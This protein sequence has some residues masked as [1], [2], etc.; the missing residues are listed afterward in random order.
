MSF[1]VNTF[2]DRPGYER[3]SSTQMKQREYYCATMI[4]R[5]WKKHHMITSGRSKKQLTV[6][7]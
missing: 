5:A 3:V 4:K 2:A 6:E 7:F 1:Y